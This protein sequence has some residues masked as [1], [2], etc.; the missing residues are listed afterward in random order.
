M[1]LTRPGKRVALFLLNQQND[2]QAAIGRGAVEAAGQYGMA[3]EVHD[4]AG[5]SPRQ[6]EQIQAVLA[7]GGKRE[8]GTATL[9]VH[10]VFD[11]VHADLAREAARAG[12]GWVLL[13]RGAE[14]ID[15]LR[16]AYPR[17]ALFTVTPDQTEIGRAQGR[18]ARALL[19]AGG[20]VLSVTGPENAPSARLRRAG[21]EDALAGSGIQIVRFAAEFSAASGEA[22]IAEWGRRADGP[23]PGFRAFT[24]DV[25]I[26]HNDSMA[27]G[28]RRAL[29]EVARRRGSP[30][31][32]QAPIVGC[33]G[34]SEFGLRLIAEKIITATVVVPDTARAA[35]DLLAEAARSGAPPP[36][37]AQLPVK[38]FPPLEAVR[39]IGPTP[40]HA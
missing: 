33:D 16:R 15:D 8:G 7:A 37:Q 35:I 3:L 28:V 30:A 12:F 40:S 38:T 11:G 32:A 22:A 36:A 27:A 10:P 2:Y 18:L 5:Q 20:K 31:L 9:L 24:P 6:R 14:Y 17:L 39:P 4:A 23:H 19:P 25:V 21:I 29:E 1:A 34:T 26:T 13:N